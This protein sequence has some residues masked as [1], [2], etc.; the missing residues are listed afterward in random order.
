M[1]L[2]KTS[3]VKYYQKCFSFDMPS[4]LWQKQITKFESKFTD[5]YVKV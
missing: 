5:F 3:S 1:K 2:F 4:S